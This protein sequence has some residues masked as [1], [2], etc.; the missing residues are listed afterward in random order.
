MWPIHG[1]P[2]GIHWLAHF[3]FAKICGSPPELN[4]RPL[5]WESDLARLGLPT[6]PPLELVSSM[7]L[8]IYKFAHVE[9]WWKK[10]WGLAPTPNET[11]CMA[12]PYNHT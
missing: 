2:R 12:P 10:G 3:S 4:Q 9:K 7:V 1:L 11:Y 5:V 6:Y 8:L